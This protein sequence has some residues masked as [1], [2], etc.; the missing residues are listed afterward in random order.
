MKKVLIVI[1][2]IMILF[3]TGCSNTMT[4]KNNSEININ[5]N[6]IKEPLSPSEENFKKI[7]L[8]NKDGKEY[9]DKYPN[10][11]LVNFKKINPSEFE[12]LK[13]S[14]NYKGLYQDLPQKELYLVDFNGGS[15]LSLTTII[16]LEEENVIKIFGI[17]IM[18]MG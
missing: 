2:V 18:E 17:Y 4:N 16:D 3:F 9:I 12:S 6:Q 15:Q 5:D 1:S 7:L 14:T 13:N 8:T 11:K 10:T